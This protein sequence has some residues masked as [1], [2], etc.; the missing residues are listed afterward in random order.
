SNKSISES[1]MTTGYA[2]PLVA[3]NPYVAG[4][5]FVDYL[6]L[7]R[8]HLIPKHPEQLGP[9]NLG[10]LTS[11]EEPAQNLESANLQIPVA[12]ASSFFDASVD[13]SAS[14]VMKGV[15]TAHE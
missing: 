12:N 13:E 14:F 8:F 5:I 2:I 1:L 4:G 3:L 15:P 10:A 7:G 11:P 6:A 9:T